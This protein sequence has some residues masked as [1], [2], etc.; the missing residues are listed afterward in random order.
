MSR[1]Q[2]KLGD[3]NLLISCVSQLSEKQGHPLGEMVG[4][5]I[6]REGRNEIVIL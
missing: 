6:S 2:S 4:D 3:L 1:Y 5:C